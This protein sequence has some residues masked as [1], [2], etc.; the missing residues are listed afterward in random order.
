M[1]SVNT[2]EHYTF[3]KTKRICL[4]LQVSKVLNGGEK[5]FLS[6]YFSAQNKTLPMYNFP[7]REAMLMALPLTYLVHYLAVSCSGFS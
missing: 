7:K 3:S 1:Y 4:K 2:S 6:S 5:N